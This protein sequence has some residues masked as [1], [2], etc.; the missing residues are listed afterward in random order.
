MKKEQKARR[1]AGTRRAA[2]R[3]PVRSAPTSRSTRPPACARR[4]RHDRS[5]TAR[6]S[7]L[8]RPPRSAARCS[9][10]DRRCGASRSTAR[11]PTSSRPAARSARARVVV[12]T[13][14]PTRAVQVAGAA[15]LVPQRRSSRSPSRCRRKSGSSWGAARRCCATPREPPHLVRWVGDD[16][17]LVSRRRHRRAAAAAARQVRGPADRSVDVR[18]LDVVSGYLRRRSRSTAGRRITRVRPNGLPCIGPHRNFPHHL[19]AFGDSSHSVTGAYLA[20]RMHATPPLRRFGSA[21]T[22]SSRFTVRTA[23]SANPHARDSLYT[24]EHA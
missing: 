21:P 1:D 12:A 24:R 20:S 14:M 3:T 4:R 9:S 23:H 7:A 19:F 22:R 17:L 8:P 6:A 16:R 15:L 18:A 10:S 5:R 11:S 13:G 2:A